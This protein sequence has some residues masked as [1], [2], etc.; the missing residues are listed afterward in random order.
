LRIQHLSVLVAILQRCLL[1]GDIPRASRAW[2]MLLRAQHN[3]KGIDIRSSGYWGIGAELLIRGGEKPIRRRT[4]LKE[5]GNR[6]SESGEEDTN[7]GEESESDEQKFHVQGERRWG[8]AA[9]LEKAKDYYER[10][11]L[12][13]PYTRQYHGSINSLDFWPAML[14]CE[15]YG[16]QFEQKEALRKLA[17][18]EES[19]DT[20]MA[21]SSSE[22]DQ[23]LRSDDQD[24]YFA[25]QQNRETQH[26]ARKRDMIWVKRDQIRHAALVAAD[27]VA[28]RMDELMVTPPYSDSHALQRLRGMLALY[29]GDLSVPGQFETDS[30]QEEDGEHDLDLDLDPDAYDAVYGKLSERRFL[31][32]HR[33][34]D[35]ERGLAK[36][37]EERARAQKVFEKIWR[38]GGRV[39]ID[40]TRLAQG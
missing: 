23:N 29:I 15:I 6:S 38:E 27:K 33:R 36:R 13:Y 2:A 9:G 3:G 14:S 34:A 24:T 21:D 18:E 40:I 12:Q 35:H 26:R 20:A 5:D 28:A 25:A 4:A 7:G 22:E 32:R 19:E 37:S 31:R 1:E 8:T 16:I 10:L 11:I 39:D 30:E 17:V